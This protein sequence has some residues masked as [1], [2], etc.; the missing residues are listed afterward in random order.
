MAKTEY[1]YGLGRR[2]SASASVRL[3]PGKGSGNYQWQI[4]QRLPRQQQ[5]ACSRNY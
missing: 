5:D 2:K 4:R 3:I 1:F